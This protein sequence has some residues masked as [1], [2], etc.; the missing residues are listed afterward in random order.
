MF[1]VQATA[2]GHNN[3]Q[4]VKSTTRKKS[5]SQHSTH[6]IL[7][8]RSGLEKLGENEVERAGEKHLGR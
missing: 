8:H 3:D 5:D 4:G 1:Y 2:K 6:N 7:F